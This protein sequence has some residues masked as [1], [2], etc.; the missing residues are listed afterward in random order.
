MDCGRGGDA[1]HAALAAP[2]GHAVVERAP[3]GVV[4]LGGAQSVGGQPAL[5]FA[6]AA[7]VSTM[8]F[9]VDSSSPVRGGVR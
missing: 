4:Q 8:T 7:R 1:Q 2:Y 9:T 3:L 6:G 5:E